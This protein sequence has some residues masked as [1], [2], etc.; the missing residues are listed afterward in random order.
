MVT[1]S[2]AWRVSMHGGHSSESSA[3]GGSP[4]RAL[5]DRAI[6]RGLVTYGISQHAPVSDARFLYDDERAAG[7]DLAARMAQF[8]AYAADSASV[9]REYAG[10]LEVL[11]GFEAEV[12]PPATY[13]ADTQ[14][15]RQ[16]FAFDYV[17]GSVHWVDERPIDVSAQ[18][19]G[20]AVE[21]AGGLA[22]LLV[23]YYRLVAEMVEALRPEVV[24]HFDLPRL[25]SLHDPAHHEAS[26]VVGREDALAEVAR[27]GALLE[28]NT[29]GYRKG[30]G[31][32]YPGPEVVAVARSLG[33]RFTLSDD[34][35]HVDHV[36]AGLEDARNY[37]LASG[38]GTIVALG[39]S[40]GGAIER[41]EVPL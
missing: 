1:G 7:L 12:V 14:Q 18:L 5:L 22:A 36:G 13:V 27:C 19:F 20:D 40:P 9:V 38:V 17:V 28:V 39:R 30:L 10:R 33:V 2:T 41:R 4:L 31:R 32:P 25:F 24:G 37:L 29:A 35:H 34:S 23:R 21:H 3:H 15:L 16:R 8:E 11:R 26:V 6:E